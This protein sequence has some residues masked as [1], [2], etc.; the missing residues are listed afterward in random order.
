MPG[1][2]G[3]TIGRLTVPAGQRPPVG[4]QRIM[5][6]RTRVSGVVTCVPLD[7]AKAG[8]EEPVA[9]LRE[10]EQPDEERA[11]STRADDR[12]LGAE[13]RSRVELVV[14]R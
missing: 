8:V 11:R 9:K 12:P 3:G 6:R 13:G 5:R 2:P 14:G 1:S 10:A 7:G 4:D